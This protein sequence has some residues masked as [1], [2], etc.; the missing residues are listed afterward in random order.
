[1]CVCVRA[2]CA[3]CSHHHTQKVMLTASYTFSVLI[4]GLESFQG[5][6]QSKAKPKNLKHGSSSHQS[7]KM[8]TP[9]CRRLTQVKSSHHACIIIDCRLARACC[10]PPIVAQPL[11]REAT[12]ELRYISFLYCALSHPIHPFTQKTPPVLQLVPPAHVRPELHSVT[13][14]PPLS[15]YTPD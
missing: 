11:A 6:H 2:V 7:R 9:C 12:F 14:D 5:A 15:T 4:I 10:F 3:W 1:V 13:G 8:P